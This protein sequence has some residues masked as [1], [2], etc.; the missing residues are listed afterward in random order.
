MGCDIHLHQEVL[1]K[2]RWQHY[3][4]R[5]IGRDYELFGRMA[6][7]RGSTEVP[8]SLPKGAPQKMT[9]ITRL[10]LEKQCEGC[11]HNISW[12]KASEIRRLEDWYLKRKDAQNPLYDDEEPPP[13]WMRWDEMFGFV[14]GQGWADHLRDRSYVQRLEYLGIEDVRWI[15]WFDS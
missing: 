9:L 6:G 4:E 5:T 1:I 15:F 12:F 11:A 8:I 14:F 3:A 2:G 7:V 13:R 10:D